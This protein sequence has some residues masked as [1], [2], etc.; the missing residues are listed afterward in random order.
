MTNQI[1]AHMEKLN[2]FY[3]AWENLGSSMI[4]EMKSDR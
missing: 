1:H 2:Q 3:T 4:Y